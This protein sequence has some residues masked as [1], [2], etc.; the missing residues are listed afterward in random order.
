MAAT[1]QS[2]VHERETAKLVANRRALALTR[3]LPIRSPFMPFLSRRRSARLAAALLLPLAVAL[4]GC[5]STH[6][7]SSASDPASLVPASTSL[8]IG[9]TVRPDGV[10]KT[11]A[12]A[13]G[14]K[15]TRQTDPYLRL[16]PILQTP[17][18][19]TLDF[20]R[21]V[22]PW[23][24]PRAGV[25]LDSLASSSRLLSLLVGGLLG[26]PSSASS[27]SPFATPG[28]AQGAVVLDTRDLSKARSFVATQAKRA[29][30]HPV[31]YRG[32]GY[33]LAP[34]SGVALGIVDHL[35]AIGSEAGLH[36]VIDSS[37]GGPSLARSAGYTKL[38]A[39]APS[40]ALGHAYS[41]PAT[42]PVSG[43]T[44]SA[45]T[46]ASETEAARGSNGAS[47]PSGGPGFS[48]LLRLLAG[49]REANLSLLPSPTSFAIDAD[50]L[51]SGSATH[52]GGLLSSGSTG[53]RTLGELP[54]ETWL[55]IGFG[56]V[57]PS[58]GGDVQSLGNL[59][60]LGGSSAT[61][62]PPESATSGGFT[63]QGVIAGIVTP[64]NTLSADTAEA[65]R[66]FQSWM[67]SSGLFVGGSGVVNLRA[68]IVIV[69]HDPAA[70]HAAIAKLGAILNKGENSAQAVSIPG[71]DAAI[72]ARVS[73]LPVE[74][75]I[76]DGRAANG[77]T[78]FVIGV[79][80]ASVEDALKPSSTLAGSAT[81][82]AAASALGEGIQ[83]TLVVNFPQLLGLLEGVGLSED[84]TIAGL[85]PDLRTLS[86]LSGGG[87]S[88]G[89]GVERTRV[90][91]TLQSTAG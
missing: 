29:G 14:G 67:G 5:G 70:S 81:L 91:A 7:S 11:D 12:L 63:V 71:T 72:T 88:L 46:G 45:A 57:G 9:G 19:P 59:L 69:S 56:E 50:T 54:A 80:E 4:A 28:G 83:P 1:V 49:T 89:G 65:K 78:E 41:H 87:H 40:G 64:L 27:T 39:T 3:A 20:S 2:A 51:A 74:L 8:Y 55:A 36:G 23:L 66:T 33:Y 26:R 43:Q 60:S 61:A 86:T 13:A 10:L 37:L 77:Q 31:A 16:L 75:D 21:D 30:A 85:L 82:S 17:G 73:G 47:Q 6:T 84:P 32:V 53:A 18:S 15:L 58:L 90:V 25:F 76:A 34:S 79:G 48:S 44:G 52:T 35:A 68:G 22:A 24:G 38:L 42:T 62:G